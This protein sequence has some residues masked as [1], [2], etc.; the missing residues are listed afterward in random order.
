MTTTQR[1]YWAFRVDRRYLTRLDG[2][3]QEGRLRQGWGWDERQNL[4]K[5]ELDQGAA[6]NR[7]MLQVK[8]G[9]YILIPH[10]P[11]RGQI[12]IAEATED[13]DKG[14][15]FSVFETGDH[16]HIFPATPLR[17]FHRSNGKIPASLRGTF[18]NPCR[19]WKIDH[20]QKDIDEVLRIPVEDLES[21][22][23]IV[24]RWQQEIENVFEGSALQ[25]RLFEAAQKKFVKSDWEFLLADVL[26]RL[27]PGWK[28]QRTGGKV[29]V[30]HGTDILV[31]I[32]DVF[33]TGYYGIAIQVKDYKGSV[34]DRP[35]TQILKAK[36]YWQNN[37][38]QI[39]E[40]VVV[41][42]GGNKQANPELEKS[43]KAAGVRLIWSL[44][45]EELVLRSACQFISDPDR[46]TCSTEPSVDV[47]EQIPEEQ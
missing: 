9:D 41:L 21:T 20:L 37:G 32:P 2:E 6:R 43:A 45:V 5:M 16:G 15:K 7:R 47:V 27:N 35:I 31:T 14:Y 13:W 12:T 25:K 33:R 1:H 38:I 42:I 11:K 36:D 17:N 18:R 3:L 22:T 30:K 10:L 44:D 4:K 40:L 23:S 34:N 19:F 39:L 26:Q 46:Q 24:D 8:K 29:E 28:V